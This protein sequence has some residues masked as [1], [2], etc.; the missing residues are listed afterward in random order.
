MAMKGSLITLLILTFPYVL[1]AQTGIIRGT[2]TDSATGEPL[3]GVT[4][5]VEGTSTGTITDFDGK[6]ELTVA[7]GVHTL[8]ISY[9]SFSPIRIEDTRVDAGRVTVLD[10]IRLTESVGQLQEVIITAEA[11]RTSEEALLT[12]K[13]RS[14]NLLDGISAANFSRIGD[15]DAASAVKRVPGVSIEGGRYVFVRGLGDRYTKSTL[16][17]MD[18]PGVDPDRNTLQMDLFPTNIVDNLVVL[19]SF[20]ADLPGDFTG[21][22]VDI[23]TKDFPGEKTLSASVSL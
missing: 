22:I 11:I 9:V 5:Q 17:G 8:A 20:T 10:N 21:G 18:V 15:S 16:N 1:F 4:V 23:N 3:V 19:K 12:V 6:F 2:V 14:A 7:E 13:R